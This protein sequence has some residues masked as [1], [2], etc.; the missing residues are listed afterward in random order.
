MRILFSSTSGD[1]HLTPMLPLATALQAL[2]HDVAFAM[3]ETY[4]DRFEETGLTWL[5]AG[6]GPDELNRRTF[7]PHDELVGLPLEHQIFI[8]RFALGDAPGRM[9][10]L[11]RVVAAWAPDLL[12]TEPCDLA[13]PPV[14]AA[15]GLPVVLHSFGRPLA[16]QYYEAAAPFVAPLWQAAGLEP[17]ELCGVYGSVYVDIC[18][19]SL[20]GE[21]TPAGT[22]V[23]PLRP[24]PPP[25]SAVEPAWLASLPDRPTVYVTLGTIFNAVDRFRPLLSA[26]GNLDCN[27]IVTIGRDNNPADLAPLP[28]NAI[29][30]R[31]VPQDLLLPHV[32]VMV[33]HGGS[34]SMLA[35][36]AHGIPQLMLPSG[37]DQFDN[38]RACDRAGVARFL[39]P[40]DVTAEAVRDHVAV[41][42]AGD[43]YR[44]RAHALADEITRLPL[45]DEVAPELIK[46][47]LTS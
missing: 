42:L 3:H 18:P 12:V 5:A 23:L 39:L 17:R 22:K 9:V 47:Y 15:A 45:P 40:D 43:G 6:I 10:D 34:G 44:Q 7:L 32:D 21:A 1:G 26:L 36:F 11:H 4:S 19:P 25:T 16:L 28:P 24:T 30:V 37:A 46:Q 35:A 31:F 29:V 33:G 38:A 20:R 13:A 27:V 41:L 8:G 2:G 14:A